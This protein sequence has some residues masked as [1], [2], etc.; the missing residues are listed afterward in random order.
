M[1]RL[2]YLARRSRWKVSSNHKHPPPV[3]GAGRTRAGWVPS[4]RVKGCTHTL[5]SC[6]IRETISQPNSYHL[7]GQTVQGALAPREHRGLHPV[8]RNQRSALQGTW[9]LEV[10]GMPAERGRQRKP[11]ARGKEGVERSRVQERGPRERAGTRVGAGGA[12]RCNE[13]A[14]SKGRA[15]RNRGR[16]GGSRCLGDLA[17]T[18][19]AAE[20]PVGGRVQRDGGEAEGGV[21]LPGLAAGA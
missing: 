5:L 15:R 2:L 17:R 20:L 21:P 3:P 16:W 8:K 10:E 9:P 1:R 6:P 11:K 18:P 13:P 4:S 14:L 19:R 12:G 7:S